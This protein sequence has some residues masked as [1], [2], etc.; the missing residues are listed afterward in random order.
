MRPMSER[1]TYRSDLLGEEYTLIRHK[2]GLDIY[3]F[4]KR[5][6]TAYAVLATNY[7]AADTRFRLAGDEAW[8]DVPDGVAHFL[9]HKMFANED[10]IDSFEKFGALGANANAYTSH[11]Q[12]AYLFSCSEKFE[13]SLKELLTYVTHPYFTPESVEKE[14]GIIAQEIRMGDDNPSSQRY[15]QLLR[16]LYHNRQVYTHI[17]GTLDSIA[18]ITDQTLYDCYRVFY[19]LSNMVLVICGDVDIDAVLNVADQI[20]PVQSRVE[21]LRDSPGEPREIVHGK[22]SC[23]MEVAQPIFAIGIKD[24]PYGL[25][26]AER[27]RRGNALDILCEMLFNQSGELFNSLYREGLLA[28]SLGFGYD[29]GRTY[30]FVGL[31]GE[32]PDPDA[33]FERIKAAVENAK[34]NGLSRTDFIRC[35]RVMYAE[36]VREFDSTSDIADLI[37]DAVQSGIEPFDFVSIL[38]SVTFEDVES[39]LHEVFRPES[40]ALSVIY[41]KEEQN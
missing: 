1:K 41:P 35:K 36:L 23:H 5:L 31:S 24:D 39:V 32:S 22:L 6:T 34:K 26:P 17:C 29:E 7:G 21:I 8:V 20:L 28:G 2:S 27:V 13:E 14:Q 37:L 16:A 18:E 25:A 33:V 12:T 4:P 15:Y 9:E 19:N 30:A 3:V 10:G 40:Y 38:D 11:D